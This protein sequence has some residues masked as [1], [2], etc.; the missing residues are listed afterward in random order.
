M[1]RYA[2]LPTR[3]Q[4]PAERVDHAYNWRADDDCALRDLS[5]S[6]VWGAL[7]IAGRERGR[8]AR[9]SLK[10]KRWTPALPDSQPRVP[11]VAAVLPEAAPAA[12]DVAEAVRHFDAVDVFGVFVADLPLDPQPQR[13]AVGDRQGLAVHHIGQNGLRMHRVEQID[14][15]IVETAVVG[16]AHHLIYAMEHDVA[17]LRHQLCVLQE[18]S[19]RHTGPFADRG[20]AFIAIVHSDL[21]AGRHRL[22]LV[23][24]ERQ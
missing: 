10:N 2:H 1:A 15:L 9:S 23:E 14:A 5:V 7:S 12:R 21:G 19:E 20:P 24:S 6:Q 13:R 17:R 16:G 22:D 3:A 11:L 18:M 4:V 8:P